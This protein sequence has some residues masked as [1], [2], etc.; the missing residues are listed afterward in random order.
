[1]F[2]TLVQI[3]AIE[4]CGIGDSHHLHPESNSYADGDCM[5]SQIFL[6]CFALGI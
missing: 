5:V 4:G 2:E 3:K 1:M 6:I